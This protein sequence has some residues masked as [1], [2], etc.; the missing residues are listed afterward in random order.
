[1][2]VRNRLAFGLYLLLALVLSGCVAATSGGATDAGEVHK[3]HPLLQYFRTQNPQFPVIK[4]AAGDVNNDGREDLIVIYSIANDTNRMLVVLNLLEQYVFTN[5]V[6]A[7]VANQ[8]IQ[9]KD[10]DNKP[11]MEF[12]VRGVKGNSAGMAIYRVQGYM[13]EDLFGEG[14]ANCCN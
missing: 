10:I 5:E 13:L 12:I 6:P 2:N 11:P 4:C 1:M 7:P 8:H 14:M 9:F 3:D